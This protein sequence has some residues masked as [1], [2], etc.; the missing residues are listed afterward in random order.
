MTTTTTGTPAPG[1]LTEHLVSVHASISHG[2][3]VLSWTLAAPGGA[4]VYRNTFGWA[5]VEMVERE[6][7]KG[8]PV[9]L[10]RAS[11]RDGVVGGPDRPFTDPARKAIEND[12]ARWIARVGFDTL[13]ND[14]RR[15]RIMDDSHYGTAVD[16]ARREAADARRFARWYDDLA[17]ILALYADGRAAVRPLPTGTAFTTHDRDARRVA[18][19][20]HDHRPTIAQ[21]VA[22]LHADGE[23]VGYLDADG[24]PIPLGADLDGYW[25]RN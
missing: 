24:N 7:W 10:R 5:Y 11:R 3:R 19:M 22:E 12:L 25:T 21:V 23:H 15:H 17:E 14:A 8:E 1:W 2:K 20:G 16:R 18:V 4:A 6:P 9:G 13:W